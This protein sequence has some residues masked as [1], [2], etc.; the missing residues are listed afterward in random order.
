MK[1]LSKKTYASIFCAR[2]DF[3]AIK[4]MGNDIKV[5]NSYKTAKAMLE[6]AEK[7]L[8]DFEDVNPQWKPDEAQATVKAK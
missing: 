6:L 8:N 4:E 5:T 3:K 7:W 1:P 2:D